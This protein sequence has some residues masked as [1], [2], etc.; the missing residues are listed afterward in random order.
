MGAY[1]LSPGSYITKM[2]TIIEK[3]ITSTTSKVLR[4]SVRGYSTE[5]KTTRN[6]FGRKIARHE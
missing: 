3:S 6:S 1:A 4:M 5:N 2:H